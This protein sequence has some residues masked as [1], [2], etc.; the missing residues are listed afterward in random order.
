VT[1]RLLL[2]I[3]GVG[4]F[5]LLTALPARHLG[6][7]DLAVVYGGTAALLC[8]VPAVVTL[9]W[10]GWAF[11]RDAQQQLTMV[12]GGTGVRLFG[13]LLVAFLLTQYVPLY[14]QGGFWTWLLVN[15]LFVLALEM[16]LVLT[17]RPAG[18]AGERSDR[19]G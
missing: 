16:G 2:L 1:A 5:W 6:G 13:V 9:A 12:L 4:A 10:A 18:P 17:A 15:Y 14:Q 8:L 3:G 19:A 7:G 11:R